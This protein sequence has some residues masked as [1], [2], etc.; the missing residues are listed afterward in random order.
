MGP[1]IAVLDAVTAVW[2]VSDLLLF[3]GYG[4]PVVGTE[5]VAFLGSDRSLVLGLGQT[6]TAMSAV[7]T[8]R[9]GMRSES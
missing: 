5:V 6:T 7:P 9:V 3:A 1:G 4:K 8:S 2:Q